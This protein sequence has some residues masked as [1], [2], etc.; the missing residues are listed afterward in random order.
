MSRRWWWLIGLALLPLGWSLG[1]LG[2]WQ[3]EVFMVSNA[4]SL[5][6]CFE[7]WQQPPLYLVLLHG[8][9]RLGHTE[10]WL[11][12]LSLGLGL[13]GAVL[14]YRQAVRIVDRRTARLGLVLLVWS[15]LF[16][17]STRQVRDVVCLFAAEWWAI[18]CFLRALERGRWR[19]WWGYALAALIGFGIN[20]NAVL[21]WGAR[22][23]YLVWLRRREPSALRPWLVTQTAVLTPWLW[24]AKIR[25]DLWA[26]WDLATGTEY[27]P[28]SWFGKAG[29]LGFTLGLGE[30]VFPWTWLVVIPAAVAFV[31]LG[32]QGLTG[33]WQ[34][35]AGRPLVWT[36]LTVWLVIAS[37]RHGGSK[38]LYPWLPIVSLLLAEGFWRWRA[39]RA[40]MVALAIVIAAFGYSNLNYFRQREYHTLVY[41]EPWRNVAAWMRPELQAGDLIL[42]TTKDDALLY[43][44]EES[45]ARRRGLLSFVEDATVQE[46]SLERPSE[47]L[48]RLTRQPNALLAQ[49]RRA[50]YRRVWLVEMSPGQVA[51]AAE[52]A[53]LTKLCEAQLAA[54]AAV[55]DQRRF[56]HDPDAAVK[57]RW[58]ADHIMDDRITITLF[59]L[60]ARP[61][62][63]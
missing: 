42:Q 62:H 5:A 19:D 58:I 63:P 44:L 39:R 48:A 47:A 18:G 53:A 51:E 33:L 23:G 21:G 3:D 49:L 28:V 7:V 13:L 35:P 38:Y 61:L 41:L 36:L 56:L 22:A 16:L 60:G 11:R 29:Y 57:R 50:G 59:D 52:L 24:L 2:L 34:R 6:N 40:A 45:S 15:P 26:S 27:L 31:L 20:Y 9:L 10:T 32:S 17:F 25:E 14:V 1:R 55:V 43:Y 46:G 8:W 30:T 54:Q 12:S 37:S 4:A